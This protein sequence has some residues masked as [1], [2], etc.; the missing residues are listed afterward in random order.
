LDPSIVAE[1]FV[2][3]LTQANLPDMLAVE[4]TLSQIF[5]QGGRKLIIN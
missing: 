1:N 3:G 4:P 5:G 2:Y